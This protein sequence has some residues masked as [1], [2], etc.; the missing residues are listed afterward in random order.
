MER[1]SEGA[2]DLNDNEV[3]HNCSYSCYMNLAV[4][5]NKLREYED[6]EFKMKLEDIM[7]KQNEIKNQIS[8]LEKELKELKKIEL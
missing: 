6:I 1:L 3:F 4:A 2:I 7:S 5:L 8:K